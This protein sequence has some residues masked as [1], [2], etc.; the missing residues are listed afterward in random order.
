MRIALAQINP[1]VGDLRG[2]TELVISGVE[3]AKTAGAALVIFP[4]LAIV[5]YPPVD[6]LWN[7]DFLAANNAALKQIAA[8]SQ[9]ISVVVGAV[10]VLTE[11]EG[12]KQRYPIVNESLASSRSP[13]LANSAFYFSHGELV[14][15]QA[16]TCLPNYDVFDETRY[17]LPARGCTLF[18]IEG[19]RFGVSICEDLWIDNG[20][21]DEQVRAGAEFLVNISASPFHLNKWQ[22]RRNLLRKRT[23]TYQRPLVYVN[24]VGGQDSLIFD[25]GSFACDA[26][27]RLIALGKFFQPDLIVVDIDR[28]GIVAEPHMSPMEQLHQ[29]LVLGLRD[30]VQK[31]SFSKVVLGLSGGID[32]AVVACLA[33]AALGPES[34]VA[35]S[36]PGPYSSRSSQL[37]AQE[38]AQNL[39]IELKTIPITAVYRSYLAVLKSEFRGLPQNVAEQNIQARIR[40]NILMALSNKH[41]WLVLSTGNKSE[42]AVGYNTL[43]GDLAGGLGVISDVPKTMVYELAR[44]INQQK[45]RPI[46]PDEVLNRAPSAELRPNQTDQDDLP[47]YDI[48]DEILHRYVEENQSIAEIVAAGFARETVQ[49]VIERVDR[50][51]YKRQQAPLGLKVTSK[52]F[53]FGRRMPVTNKFRNRIV[54]EPEVGKQ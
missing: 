37:C 39:Y 29:A 12:E 17:F 22:L 36:M 15:T 38:L 3:Q 53:G 21:A 11:P 49:E 16:K 18:Q 13:R 24:C 14:A 2:N 42:I 20:P 35:V 52:A 26:R 51:E 34:V 50:S 47:P 1:T 23:L 9:D 5:G 43:Y 10:E 41:G 7:R 6:L 40:G 19:R 31:N 4:E 54:S 44:Y 27:G 33:K 32:S 25:G 48:L 28:S 46:I 8:A 30:Y 45:G